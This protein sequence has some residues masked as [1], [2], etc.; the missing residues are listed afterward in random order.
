MTFPFAELV[1]QLQAELGNSV[2]LRRVLIPLGRSLQR[3]AAAPD[4]FQYPRAVAAF[5]DRLFLGYQEKAGVL[6]VL[7]Y[8]AEGGRFE[9]QLVQDYRA[10]GTFQRVHAQRSVCL[11]CHQNQ[12]PLFPRQLWDETN[13]NA[14][15]R[16]LLAAQHREFYGFPLEITADVPYQIDLAVHRAN[17]FSVAHRIGTT[18]VKGWMETWPRGLWIPNPEIANR[19][20]MAALSRTAYSDDRQRIEFLTA[21]QGNIAAEFEPAVPRPALEIWRAEDPDLSSKVA[22]VLK[23][24]AVQ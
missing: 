10:G 4:F 21:C 12:A 2:P 18:G 8:N 19:S 13:A 22:A 23:T 20:P 3:S 5:G 15:I 1:A 7:S 24:S 6:E 9:F 11:K 17:L 14:G 16:R